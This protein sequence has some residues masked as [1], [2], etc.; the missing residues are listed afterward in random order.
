MTL[1]K[2]IVRGKDAN[3]AAKNVYENKEIQEFKRLN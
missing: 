1:W 2:I 3:E